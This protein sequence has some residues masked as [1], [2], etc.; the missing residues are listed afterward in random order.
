MILRREGAS[1]DAW[2]NISARPVVDREQQ[3]TYGAV[4][5]FRDITERK[6]A[7]EAMDAE[8]E[9]KERLLEAHEQERALLAY[10]VHDGLCQDI[11]AA[12]MHLEG[13]VANMPGLPAEQ[14]Q[15]FHQ[16]LCLLGDSIDEG[17][18]VMNGLRPPIIDEFGVIPAIEY[19]VA[20]RK[21]Q[22][23]PPIEFTHD[24]QFDRLAPLLE[25]TIFRIA[26][27]ALNNVRR[28][29]G[30]RTARIDLTQRGDRVLL[31][32]SDDGCGF[33]AEQVDK[34]RFG[35]RG[36]RERARVLRGKASIDST[37]GQGTRV[38]VE[39]PLSRAH[40]ISTKASLP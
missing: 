39:L 17:R 5:A 20:G 4:A 11:A 19:L 37:P 35:L 32:V 2:L 31:E 34:R 13:L 8:Q 36:I 1:E 28:H 3:R 12:K 16:V 18:R 21:G 30:A 40:P 23:G 7:R 6:L 22:T 10:E 25:G 33:Q 27:E 26:Q 38:R 15:A 29:S 24:V 14:Q 9:F